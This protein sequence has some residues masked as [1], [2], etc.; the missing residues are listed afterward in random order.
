[1]EPLWIALAALL[2]GGVLW[3]IGRFFWRLRPQGELD[4]LPATPLEKLGW[5]GLGITLAIGAGLSLLVAF[6]G[7]AGV[8]DD[9]T[10]LIFWL[11]ILAGVAVWFVAWRVIDPG[12]LPIRRVGRRRVV[13]RRLDDRPHGG[14]SRRR[15]RPFGIRSAHLLEHTHRRLRRAITGDRA[16]LPP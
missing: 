4:G 9:S 7:V 3:G 1:M 10:V 5:I 16:G 12:S 13:A 8:F 14:L 6:E 2:G 15:R 11:L